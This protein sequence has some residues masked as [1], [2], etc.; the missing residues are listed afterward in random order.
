MLDSSNS[1]ERVGDG[2]LQLPMPLSR[3][4]VVSVNEQ[5]DF[6]SN[7]PGS[8]CP[9][10]AWE[11]PQMPHAISNTETA[12]AGD[13]SI[14]FSALSEVRLEIR[15]ELQMF[16]QSSLRNEFV[17]L[18]TRIKQDVRILLEELQ[19]AR[20]PCKTRLHSLELPQ[21]S[22]L[23]IADCSSL[24]SKNTGGSATITRPSSALSD[25]S[26]VVDTSP[27]S[28]Q[29][30]SRNATEHVLRGEMTP[31]KQAVQR[32]VTGTPTCPKFGPRNFRGY[33][34]IEAIDKCDVK[35]ESAWKAL[36][37]TRSPSAAPRAR[38]S[39]DKHKARNSVEKHKPAQ[40]SSMVLQRGLSAPEVDRHSACPATVDASG[41]E[42][43]KE[44]RMLSFAAVSS[45]PTKGDSD[46]DGDER[47]TRIS[48]ATEVLS[49]LRDTVK[50]VTAAVTFRSSMQDRIS[51]HS[52]S[53]STQPSML[54][55]DSPE[56][57]KH[58]RHQT[59][60]K[61]VFIESK[62]TRDFSK[63]GARH[64]SKATPPALSRTWRLAE[65]V[66]NHILFDFLS[67]TFVFLNALWIG[68]CTDL[69][70]LGR[71][72][73]D[74]PS[75]SV[76]VVDTGFAA[77]FAL[78]LLL[79]VYVYRCRFFIMRGKEWNWFDT[80]LVALQVSE[81]WF[82]WIKTNSSGAKFSFMRVLRILRLVRVLR[83]VRIVRLIGELRTIIYSIISTWKSLGWTMVLL[84]LIIYVVGIFFTQLVMDHAEE[85][86]IL[87]DRFGSVSKSLLSLFAAITGGVDW[88]ALVDEMIASIHPICGLV[89]CV[90]IA[91]AVLAMLNIVTG[92]F[93]DSALMTARHDK[94]VDLVNTLR[95]V[96]LNTDED[97]TGTISL[98]EFE[99]HIADSQMDAVFKAVD[100]DQS[101]ARG[102]FE[103]IDVENKGEISR[104]DFIM[105]CLRLKGPAKAL[106][107]AT[108]M[109]DTKRMA[110]ML[111]EHMEIIEETLVF[112]GQNPATSAFALAAS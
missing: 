46:F 84:T 47:V 111:E 64:I 61:A 23:P 112:Q 43:G 20:Q 32:Q 54:H 98:G 104:E 60:R 91:F 94:D 39:L 99:E 74:E 107:L 2:S 38:N 21:A 13:A 14:D 71:E 25:N 76:R 69:V 95:E 37:S 77:F 35:E 85:N 52:L 26:R 93:V 88:V 44:K 103:L 24:I 40:K 28:V 41:R 57:K 83:L 22:E 110:N 49:G 31:R 65:N 72:D 97:G 79:R 86:T 48:K 5:R 59:A 3:G 42:P 30:L 1:L 33:M 96:F 78:E 36:G 50:S 67:G 45:E 55:M 80:I 102:L 53:H 87:Q 108:L 58:K 100:L 62:N 109:F 51:D 16:Y 29:R 11:L 27:T 90:Y 18:G 15:Q 10:P 19:C 75:M 34:A 89:Y 101:E 7:M 92:V 66:V 6:E 82:V 63:A 17:N 4:L 105:G 9:P 73:K 12:Y 81:E 68:V 106:D 70:A 56:N 8:P